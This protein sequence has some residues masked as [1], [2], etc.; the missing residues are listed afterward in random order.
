[1]IGVEG[2]YNT[3]EMAQQVYICM[4]ACTIE[5]IHACTAGMYTVHMS[6][7]TNTHGQKVQKIC[8]Y[9]LSVLFS[10][11]FHPAQV[12]FILFPNEMAI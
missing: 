1:M 3:S 10:V 11:Y 5:C 7:H 2:I 6:H 9:K 4:P 12:E 8:K